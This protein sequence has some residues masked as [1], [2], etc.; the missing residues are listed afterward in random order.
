MTESVVS[1]GEHVSWSEQA[2]MP[3]GA[4]G[5][6]PQSADVVVVGGGYC[7][8][9]AARELARGGRETVLIEQGP[10]GSGASGR[11]GGFVHAGVRRT[12]PELLSRFGVELG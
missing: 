11:Y 2:E 7:G 5:A 10:L 9:A 3:A 8:A 4:T 6:L 12:L 1:D